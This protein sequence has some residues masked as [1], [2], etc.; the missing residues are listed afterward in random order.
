VIG[1]ALALLAVQS[2]SGDRAGLAPATADAILAGASACVGATVDPAGQDARL[3]GWSAPTAAEAKAIHTGSGRQVS[4]EN[5][6]VTVKAGID[7]GCV[8]QASA[9]PGFDK[10]AFYAAL[11]QRIGVAAS[12]DKPVVT[13]P[14]GE[15]MVVQAGDE[16]GKTFVQLVVANPN[17]KY[18]KKYSK[19][20]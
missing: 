7:G 18:A 15:L 6:V 19:G 2:A 8:V 3:A 5:V 14:D 17:G 20:N 11:T 1:A 10:P 4:R 9:G 13:L 12:A 16:G